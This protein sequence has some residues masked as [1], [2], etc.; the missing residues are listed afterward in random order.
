MSC[1]KSLPPFTFDVLYY[2]NRNQLERF[3]IVCRPLKNFIDRYFHSKPYRVFNRLYIYGGSY[4]LDHD[5][6]HWYPREDYSMQQF[7]AGQGRNDSFIYYS[8]AEMRPYLGP[9]IRIKRTFIC[10]AGD[11]TYNP[12]QIAEMESITYLWSDGNV[13]IQHADG[14]GSGIVAEDFQ[15]I[16][17]SPTILQCR[18]LTMDCPLFSF[19]DHNV[20]YNVKVIRVTYFYDIDPA[21][22][23]QFLEQPGVKPVVVMLHFD[24]ANIDNVL[25]LL[26]KVI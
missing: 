10:V 14:N 15:L 3:S 13:K 9:T 17:N 4:V 24:R 26:C 11:S 23:A 6:S 20:L 1:S 16:L 8:F 2:L 21:H 18:D 5:Y 12:E 19:N 25:D 22:F 7:L